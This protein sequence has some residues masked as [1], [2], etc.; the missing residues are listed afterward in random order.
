MEGGRRGALG[1]A[2]VG[3]NRVLVAAT[4]VARSV[5]IAEARIDV[6]L[7]EGDS[8]V[9]GPGGEDCYRSGR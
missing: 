9:R 6:A 8:G 3:G 4:F 5:D 7:G 1:C 2:R